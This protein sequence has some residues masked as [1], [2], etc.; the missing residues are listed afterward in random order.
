MQRTLSNDQIVA[1]IES[2]IER[3]EYPENFPALPE[4]PAARYTSQEFYELEVEHVFKTVMAFCRPC[5]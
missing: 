1:A 4:V 3:R 2:G 5:Q